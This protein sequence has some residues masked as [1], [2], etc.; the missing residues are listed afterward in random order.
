MKRPTAKDKI[1][2]KS[3]DEILDEVCVEGLPDPSEGANGWKFAVISARAYQKNT[4]YFLVGESGE[5]TG[6]SVLSIAP[7]SFKSDKKR[8]VFHAP[9]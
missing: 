9:M 2:I 5:E 6:I 1:L 7:P 8:V 3:G 4:Q